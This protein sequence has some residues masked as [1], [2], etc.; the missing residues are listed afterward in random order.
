MA[1]QQYRMMPL[2]ITW[3]SMNWET[4]CTRHDQRFVKAKYLSWEVFVMQAWRPEFVSSIPVKGRGIGV[5]L[6]PQSW[7][8]RDRGILELA[9]QSVGLNQLPSCSKKTLSQREREILTKRYNVHIW[10]PHEH[11]SIHVHAHH[12]LGNYVRPEWIQQSQTQA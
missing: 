12:L 10:L 9:S 5:H 1:Q 11:V 8:R 2:L 4:T 7:E 3:T 6:Q